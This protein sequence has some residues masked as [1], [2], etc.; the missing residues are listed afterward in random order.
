MSTH[1]FSVLARTLASAALAF[2][3]MVCCA[4]A[5]AQGAGKIVRLGGDALIIRSSDESRAVVDMEI[6]ESDIITTQALSEVVIKFADGGVLAIRPSSQVAISSF[7]HSTAPDSTGSEQSF[8]VKMLHGGLRSITGLIGKLNPKGVIFQARTATIGIRGTDFEISD[9]ESDLSQA[10]AG[11]YGRVFEGET[12]FED[13]LGQ[14]VNVGANQV[15]FSPRVVSGNGQLT[16]LRGATPSV[17]FGG[18]FDGA[19]GSIR[20]SRSGKG[21]DESPSSES[22]KESA[23]RKNTDTL[24]DGSSGKDSANSGSG[25]SGSGSSGSG[26]SGS[27]SSGSGSSGS[28]SSGSGSSGSG[29]SGSGSSGS[30][31]SGGTSSG[32]GTSGKGTSGK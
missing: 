2:A 25:T 4:N 19:L 7:R 20:Q 24:K 17:F 31:S 3:A 27:G 11:V 21:S 10:A 8:V 6:M 29:S 1:P 13:A 32:G 5:F 30:G 14:R 28:G 26:S 12:Y 18:R 16:L 15:A 23:E 22:E 9:I